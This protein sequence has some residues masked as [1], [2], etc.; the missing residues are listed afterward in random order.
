MINDTV[1]LDIDESIEPLLA[2]VLYGLQ[3]GYTTEL[4]SARNDGRQL[5]LKLNSQKRETYNFNTFGLTV[6]GVDFAYCR[7][8]CDSSQ[9]T[10]HHRCRVQCGDRTYK[11]VYPSFQQKYYLKNKNLRKPSENSTELVHPDNFK[12]LD[13]FYHRFVFYEEYHKTAVPFL[14]WLFSTGFKNASSSMKISGNAFYKIKK[15]LPLI[16]NP[17][18]TYDVNKTAYNNLIDFLIAFQT[19]KHRQYELSIRNFTLNKQI[20]VKNQ[21]QIIIQYMG[22]VIFRE[23]SL[24]RFKYIKHPGL[25]LLLHGLDNSELPLKNKYN[26]HRLSQI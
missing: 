1:V 12:P 18:Q 7:I 22:D 4:L 17:S 16:E 26:K 10:L 6:E 21:T 2:V 25:C 13:D 15:F 24:E 14:Y 8:V 20:T 9:I 5:H 11:S 23:S 3:Y 19:N